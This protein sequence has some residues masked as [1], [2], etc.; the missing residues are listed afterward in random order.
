[1]ELIH[2]WTAGIQH[3]GLNKNLSILLLYTTEFIRK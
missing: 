1:M 3:D 2:D